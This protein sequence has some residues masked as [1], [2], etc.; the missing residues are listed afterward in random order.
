MQD[1]MWAS[2]SGEVPSLMKCAKHSRCLSTSDFKFNFIC[3]FL[4]SNWNKVTHALSK[5]LKQTCEVHAGFLMETLH[6]SNCLYTGP[7]SALDQNSAVTSE[8]MLNSYFCKRIQARLK[9]GLNPVRSPGKV[10]VIEA[11]Y[12]RRTSRRV[13]ETSPLLLSH[14]EGHHL[15]LEIFGRALGELAVLKEKILTVVYEHASRSS[16]VPTT[17]D[18]LGHLDELPQLHIK[19]DQLKAPC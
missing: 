9:G 3:S 10:V 1:L 4:H 12:W 6:L 14:I 5:R 15:A 16:M 7:K 19:L 11:C 13:M 2:Q 8:L 18:T 17:S